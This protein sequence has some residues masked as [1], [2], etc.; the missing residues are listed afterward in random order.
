M[1]WYLDLYFAFLVLS[2]YT[3]SLVFN[4]L[5]GSNII[6]MPP[7]SSRANAGARIAPPPAAGNNDR[8]DINVS[9]LCVG[10]IIWLPSKDSLHDNIKCDK[11]QCCGG[12]DL[13]EGGYNHP[14]IVL[15]IKQRPGSRVSGDLICSVAC[16]SICLNIGV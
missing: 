6:S 3:F 14:V 12:G 11:D 2:L 1:P 10:C 9:D 5:I 8:S 13:G 15:R 7:Q 4:F 16:V